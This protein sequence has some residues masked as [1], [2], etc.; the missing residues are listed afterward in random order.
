MIETFK[1]LENILF[2]FNSSALDLEKQFVFE[3]CEISNNFDNKIKQK[4]CQVKIKSIKNEVSYNFIISTLSNFKF[5]QKYKIRVKDIKIQVLY[6]QTF[7]ELR[8]FEEDDRFSFSQ[9]FSQFKKENYYNMKTLTYV[10]YKNEMEKLKN[11]AYFI[12][13]KFREFLEQGDD[14]Q[15]K[16]KYEF[17]DADGNVIKINSISEEI[18]K[19]LE[20]NKIYYLL[21]IIINEHN[22]N[23]EVINAFQI[24]KFDEHNFQENFLYNNELKVSIK[25]GNKIITNL[26]GEIIDFIL[27]EKT[28]KIKEIKTQNFLTLKL[29]YHLFR[30][31]KLNTI[32]KFTGF[33]KVNNSY[34]IFNETSEIF[35]KQITYLK[36]F[37]LDY[38]KS[39]NKYDTICINDIKYKIDSDITEIQLDTEKEKAI[40]LKKIILLNKKDSK[41]R[42]EYILEIENGKTININNFVNS[43]GRFSY[44]VIFQSTKDINLPK[45]YEIFLKNSQIVLNKFDKYTDGKLRFNIINIPNQDNLINDENK[46][47]SLDKSSKNSLK[48]LNLINDDNKKELYKFELEKENNSIFSIK[49][50]YLDIINSFFDNNFNKGII[51]FSNIDENTYKYLNDKMEKEEFQFSNN[52]ADYGLIKRFTFYMLC[53]KMKE[54]DKS[55][56]KL[57]FIKYI[58]LLIDSQ[59]LDYI[60]K[61]NILLFYLNKKIKDIDKDYSFNN[62]GNSDSLN[63]QGLEEDILKNEIKIDEDESTNEK[64]NPF[65]LSYLVFLKIIDGLNEKSL[66]FHYLQMFNSLILL[67]KNFKDTMY[68][69]NILDIKTIKLEIF[70]LIHPYLFFENSPSRHYAFYSTQFQQM[71]I[72][73][74]LILEHKN[75]KSLSSKEKERLAGA[76]NFL[77]FHEFCGHSKTHNSNNNNT[78]RFIYS[79]EFKLINISNKISKL[80]SGFIIEYLLTSNSIAIESFLNSDFSIELLNKDLYVKDN[81]NDLQTILNKIPNFFEIPTKSDKDIESDSGHSNVTINDN[82]NDDADKIIKKYHSKFFGDRD[83]FAMSFKIK[84]LTDKERKKLEKT[85]FYKKYL[86]Y[87]NTEF[88]EEKDEFY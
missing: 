76:I 58:N 38:N 12:K 52:K 48:I 19:E 39:N 30:K 27:S 22:N 88:G 36:F 68:S 20:N 75:I 84:K 77:Y 60:E 6:Y 4:Y 3:I 73:L 83:Y 37:N 10:S 71:G 69:G 24:I 55:N 15:I 53:F 85:Q 54:L 56:R 47:I 16:N 42:K 62:F 34:Y 82:S 40:F 29:N 28:I 9:F 18:I 65:L 87:M 8:N 57:E 67:E 74:K 86:E 51:D 5:E 80:D 13:I 61:I 70:H 72:D 43:D 78:P 31:I 45:S 32:C 1:E 64:K 25:T 2:S 79:Q 81:F 21:G 35:I 14:F 41:I 26:E 33:K 44:Q 46:I 63:N 49:G 23:F 11:S 50:P 17:F 59:N 7:Y 66:L